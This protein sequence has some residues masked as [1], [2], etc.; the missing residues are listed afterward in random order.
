MRA[1]TTYGPTDLICDQ[2][3]LTFYL[4][5]HQPH[6][7]RTAPIDIPLFISHKTLGEVKNVCRLRP[8]GLHRRHL[9]VDSGAFSELEKHGRFL[10][11]PAQYVEALIRYDTELTDLDWA[12]PQDH[13][14]EPFIL[15]KTGGSVRSHQ[16]ATVANFLELQEMWPTSGH[17]DC[18][19]MPVVQG[20]SVDDYHRCVD[21]YESAGVWLATDY[22]VVGVGSVCRRQGMAVAGDIFRTLAE[23]DLPLHGFGVKVTGLRRFGRWLTTADSMAWSFGARH[24]PPL[25]GCAHGKTGAGNCANCLIYARLWYRSTDAMAQAARD[26]QRQEPEQLGFFDL[27]D[28]VGA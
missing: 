3:G 19:I 6:W 14:C 11:P 20:W 21:L 1:I 10:T 25:P 15:A 16:E 12:A 7:C 24:E 28:A 2:Q 23:R 9:A 18:P 8:P 27:L 17:G 13:M 4:G 5:T 26:V 22:P